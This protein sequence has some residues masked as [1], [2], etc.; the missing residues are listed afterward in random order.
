MRYVAQQYP[1]H[2]RIEINSRDCE[3]PETVLSEIQPALNRLGKTVESLADSQ[4]WLTVVYHPKSDVYHAHAK[5]KVPGE[6]IITGDQNEAIGLALARCLDKVIRRA[7]QYVDNPDQAAIEAARQRQHLEDVIA[8]TDPDAGPI[9]QAV[10]NGDYLAFRKA[11]LNQEEPL[12]RRV[13]RWI[14][15]YPKLQAEVGRSFEIADLVEAVFLT[16]FEQYPHR[17][18]HLAFHE[19]L[20][21]LIDVAVKDFWHDPDAR[22]AAS[23][24]QSLL[25]LT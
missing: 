12:R 25:G 6:T 8:P 10:Q 3:I 14:Q 20:A 23:A 22:Q 19:W 24:A 13:G 2:L 4:F 15:R 5:L 1:H 17:P 21:S 18:I 9:G 7:E 11:L 16:A